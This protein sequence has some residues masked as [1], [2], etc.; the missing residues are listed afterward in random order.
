[1][2]VKDIIL[3]LIRFLLYN[4]DRA[5]HAQQAIK[6]LLIELFLWILHYPTMCAYSTMFLVCVYNNLDTGLDYLYK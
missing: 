1:M 2:C 5:D 4:L 3:M 6:N